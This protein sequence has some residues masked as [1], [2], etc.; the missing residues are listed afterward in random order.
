[1]QSEELA[2]M[3]ASASIDESLKEYSNLTKTPSLNSL[4]SSKRIEL[5]D[6]VSFFFFFEKQESLRF[7]YCAY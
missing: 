3:A 6:M 7:H 1:M 2:C 5:G 4:L